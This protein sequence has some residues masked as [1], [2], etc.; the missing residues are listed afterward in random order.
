MQKCSI[1]IISTTSNVH[2]IPKVCHEIQRQK[3]SAL[4]DLHNE[5]HRLVYLVWFDWYFVKNE[6]HSNVM[7]WNSWKMFS[8]SV[9]CTKRCNEVW[10]ENYIM[11]F[12]CFPFFVL[13]NKFHRNFVTNCNSVN[14]ERLFDVN[15]C[16]GLSL[17]YRIAISKVIFIQQ[18]YVYTFVAVVSV[19]N[20]TNKIL[21]IDEMRWYRHLFLAYKES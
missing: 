6:I 19:N 12:H 5:I 7:K 8:S 15:M 4:F 20:F 10:F 2:I 1:Y 16:M 14:Q 3:T 9:S 13:M 21:H 18:F 11:T 17:I